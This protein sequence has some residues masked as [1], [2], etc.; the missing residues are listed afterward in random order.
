MKVLEQRKDLTWF[1]SAAGPVRA[2][3]AIQVRGHGDPTKVGAM[4]V[5]RKGWTLN[6]FGKNE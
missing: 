3:E 1:L 2:T 5:E 4:K 6:I